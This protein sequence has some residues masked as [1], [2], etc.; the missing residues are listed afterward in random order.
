MQNTLATDPVPL[1]SSGLG[2]VCIVDVSKRQLLVNGREVRLGGR[3]FDLL[4]ALQ[5]QQG[6]VVSKDA[7][8]DAVWPGLAVTPNNLDVQI[9]ALRRCLG[10]DAIRTVARRGYALTSAVQITMLDAVRPRRDASAESPDPVQQEARVVLPK[11]LLSGCLVLVGGDAPARL[12]LSR[13]VCQHFS[14]AASG[15]VWH[16]QA[17]HGVPAEGALR[18]LERA[19]GLLVLAEAAVAL[20]RQWIDWTR[21]ARVRRSIHLLATSA[22]V[23]PGADADVHRISHLPSAPPGEGAPTAS[24]SL[25]WQPRMPAGGR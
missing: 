6:Q 19:G 13:A 8:Q 17:T 11:L 23:H 3:A 2:V 7:L 1:P 4:L 5:A 15:P 14:Q 24:G 22:E 16:L 25:R 12:Y 9:W 20:R 18:R 10:P 21:A